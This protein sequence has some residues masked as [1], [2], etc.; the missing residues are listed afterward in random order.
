MFAHLRAA[1]D[2]LGKEFLRKLCGRH[3]GTG[4]R[5]A[6]TNIPKEPN[7]HRPDDTN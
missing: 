3:R 5:K 6:I 2:E 1:L 4:W 7:L